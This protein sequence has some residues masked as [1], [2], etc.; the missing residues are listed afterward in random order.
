MG[1]ATRAISST[2][3]PDDES[4]FAIIP[5]SPGLH[6]SS[7]RMGASNPCIH[8]PRGSHGERY[9]VESYVGRIE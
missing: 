1:Q 3:V 6:S 2:L 5:A 4:V 7:I 8:N 9:D